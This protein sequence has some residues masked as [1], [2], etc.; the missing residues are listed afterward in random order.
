MG[1]TKARGVERRRLRGQ[2]A[3]FD[4]E[5]ILV[6]A[7]MG[8]P[9]DLGAARE[10]Q[11][12][13]IGQFRSESLFLDRDQAPTFDEQLDMC[14]A[15]VPAFEDPTV[16]RTLDISGDKDV[17]CLDLPR[18]QNPFL[19]VRGLRLCL[20][21]PEP[22]DAQLDALVAASQDGRLR[23]MFPMVA[24]IAD[25][26]A[27]LHRLSARADATGVAPPAPGIM[28]ET[29]SAELLALHLAERC[30][31]FSIGTN[32][33]AQYTSAAA[34]LLLS[35]GVNEFSVAPSVLDQTRWLVTQLDPAAT[36]RAAQAAMR[37]SSA[38]AVREIAGEVLP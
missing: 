29:P 15:A 6:A 17:P 37:T 38:I 23:V 34:A 18:E 31:F 12:D 13:G 27:G 20:T 1:E 9:H 2:H 14:V 11:P 21:M 4:G 16:I 24:S 35:L 36:R 22:F 5:H 33:L 10:V 30:A 19:G 26:D 32:D 7:N 28:F 8:A 25:L 3:S